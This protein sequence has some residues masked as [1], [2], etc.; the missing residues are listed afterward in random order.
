M[1]RE[2][3]AWFTKH[4]L[5]SMLT[6][7]KSDFRKQDSETVLKRGSRTLLR[8]PQVRLTED[9]SNGRFVDW[10]NASNCVVKDRNMLINIL[11]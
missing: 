1:L 2:P 6:P 7:A 10:K 11:I 3:G 5:R 9:R 8:K 4:T